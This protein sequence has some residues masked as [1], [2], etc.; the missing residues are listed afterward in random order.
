MQKRAPTLANIL[1]IVLFAL[2]CFGLLLFLWESFGG[3]VPLKPKGYRFTVAFPRTLALAEQSDV[4]ISGVNV[5]H[6]ISLKY[7]RDGRAHVTIEVASKYAPIP[8]N[9][10]AILRQKTLLGETYVQLKPGGAGAPL[11]PDGSQLPNAQIE[12]AVTLDDILTTLTPQTRRAFQVW[13]QSAAEGLGGRGQEINS[14]F[15]TLQP[16][17]EDSN[18]LVAA[19]NSQEGALRASIHNTGA[20]FDAL[21]AR[22][23]Q[24]RGFISNGARTFHAAA[25]ASQAFAEAFHEL[26]AFERNGQ[27]ALRSLDRFATDTSPLLDQLR[28]FEERL[29][30]LL[31]A[32]KPFTPPFNSLLTSL[33][34]L[35]RAGKRGLPDVK[36]TLNLTTPVLAALS[37]VLHNFNPFFQYASEY[38]PELQALFANGT[39]ATQTHEKNKNIP[40]G[41]QQHFLK[42]MQVLTPEGL[43]VYQQ[44]IGTNRGN[45][46]P[47]PGAFRSLAGGLSV[48]SS[49][50]CANSGPSLSGPPLGTVNEEVIEQLI[51]LTPGSRKEGPEGHPGVANHAL[52]PPVANNPAAASNEI[53][54]PPCKQQGPFTFN[55]VTSQFPHAT[56]SR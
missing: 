54:A 52:Y 40:G 28:P 56:P 15:A 35:A 8:S 11:L 14:S 9:M 12:A 4:R 46:Y 32:V 22:R 23:G 43:G 21:T 18:R 2:S 17:I 48:F 37:P 44:R 16:F 41:P 6:V 51:G 10:H 55:G 47:Q 25:E 30:P 50:S 38:V 42:A 7:D 1:V 20:V 5:G 31:Q 29:T 27:T 3:P 33:G 26:P 36:K 39:A 13:M 45:A 24:F 53:P 19:A 34:P 49:A